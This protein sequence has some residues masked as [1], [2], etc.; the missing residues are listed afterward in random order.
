MV[1]YFPENSDKEPGGFCPSDS[2]FVSF[3]TSVS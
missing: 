3:P 2:L 1:V